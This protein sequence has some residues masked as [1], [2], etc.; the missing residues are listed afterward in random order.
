MMRLAL[1]IVGKALFSIDLSNDAPR[2]TEAV[3]QALDHIVERIRNPIGAPSF[4]LTPRKMRFKLA[5]ST[6]DATVY[7]MIAERVDSERYGDDLLGMLLKARDS[8]SGEPLTR[9]QVRDELITILIAGHETVASALTWTFYLLAKHPQTW[10]KLGAEVGTV[11]S[12]RLPATADLD[13][14]PFTASLFD[15]A[16]RLYPPAWIITR[17]AVEADQIGGYD[18]PP[19][20]LVLISPYTIHRHAEFWQRPEEFWPERFVQGGGAQRF[21]YI[22]FGGGPRLCIGNQFALI[23]GRMI[24]AMVAQRFQ[25]KLTDRP[26]H[27]DALVTLR[28]KGG[29]H[30]TVERV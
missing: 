30:L 27:M 2:L 23:E 15:E 21:A 22:P 19:G 10:E 26:V 28:P 12:G 5:I 24:I 14:L 29:L 17:K 4:L 1:E 3:L 13:N 9:E 16:L 7:Q 18:V 8:E 20:A 25:L 6:L 11:L